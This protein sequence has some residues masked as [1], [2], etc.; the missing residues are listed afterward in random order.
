[1]STNTDKIRKV[2]SDYFD[3]INPHHY[4]GVKINT[5]SIEPA[6]IIFIH[7]HCEDKNDKIKYFGRKG[8]DLTVIERLTEDM[9]NM[10]P[11]SF[12]IYCKW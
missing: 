1:M 9:E 7:I 5:D 12:K 8:R 10:F 2:I 4:D 3:M 6:G 11:Y